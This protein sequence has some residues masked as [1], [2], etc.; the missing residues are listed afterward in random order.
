VKPSVRIVIVNWNTGPYLRECLSALA[1]MEHESLELERVV[2]VDNASTDGSATDLEFSSLALEVIRNDANIGFAAACNLGAAGSQA[3]YLLFLNPDTRVLPDTVARVAQFMESSEAI[4][5]GICGAQVLQPDGRSAISCAR[6]P[7]PRV[8]IGKVTGLHRL[9]PRIF[10]SHHMP[11][12]ELYRSKAVDQVI[13]A[14]FFV[15][16]ELFIRL[17]GFDT[18][19]FLYYEEVDFTL[20][21]RRAGSRAYFLSDARIVH[22]ANVSSDQVRGPR[23]FHSLLSR[24]IFAYRHWPRWKAHVLVVVTYGVELPLRLASALVTGRREARL[25]EIGGAYGRFLAALVRGLPSAASL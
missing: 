14:F 7:S 19:Y 2:V 22:A 1:A 5:V 8:L 11:P 18:R 6:F 21:A 12:E 23:L 25:A 10:P 17:G 4:D 13:G 24:T 3:R 16:R 20:R 15:R 9:A